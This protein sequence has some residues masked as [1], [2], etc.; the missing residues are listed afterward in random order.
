MHLCAA[1]FLP[2]FLVLFGTVDVLAQDRPHPARD[3]RIDQIDWIDDGAEFLD[4]KRFKTRLTSK[5][6]AVDRGAI[7]DGALERARG[8]GQPLLW[9][10]YKIS[11][12]TKRGRQLIRAPVL[13]VYMRQ[14]IWNDAAVER[15]VSASFVPLRMVCDE[16]LCQRLGLRPPECL[17]PAV[18]FF[19]PDGE[20]LHVL[21]T[22]R[23]FDASWFMGVLRDVLRKAHGPLQGGDVSGALDRG[24]FAAADALLAEREGAEPQ[25]LYTRA[26]MRRRLRDGAG[27][28]AALGKV[29]E[30]WKV[31][32]GSLG[33]RGQRGATGRSA[34]SNPQVRALAELYV[35]LQV[36][37]GAVLMALGRSEEA[38]GPLR[39]AADAVVGKRRAEARYRLALIRLLS[40]DEAGALR[41]FQAIVQEHPTDRWARRA[42]PNLLLGVDDHRP[43]GATFLGHERTRWLPK[44]AQV[45]LPEDSRWPA[46]PPAVDDMVARGVRLILA[47]QRADGGWNDARYAYCPDVRIT[48]NVWV[49]ISA[50]CCQALLRHRDRVPGLADRIDVAVQRG[51]RYLMDASRINRGHN[52]DVYADAYRLLHLARHHGL[53]PDGAERRRLKLWMRAI[54]GDVAARQH[55]Q[56]FWAHEY[57]NAFCTAA[58]V[59]GLV[60]ARE[61][62]VRI[63]KDVLEKANK[64]LLSARRKNGS[65]SYG[66]TAGRGRLSDLKNASTRMPMCEAALCALGASDGERVEAAFAAFWKHLPSIE[67]VRRTDFH[68]DGEIAGF[69]FF[70]SIYHTSEA[71][72]FLPEDRR[73]PMHRRLLERLRTYSEIDGTFMDSHEMGRSYATSMALLVIANALDGD[74]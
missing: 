1:R 11:E 44:D 17:E 62:G 28:L 25:G 63:P 27:A 47:Q 70:H 49:A 22:I 73:A 68:T 3:L 31:A 48:P 32:S 9:Y 69:M 45:T 13:D 30:A 10:V 56:G 50:L 34:S 66:G 20:V 72:A 29:D 2:C 61:A 38:V 6:S 65:F 5:E 59:E 7:L 18:V 26:V 14:L 16:S 46:S 4:Q 15:V 43:L 40:G 52:E 23:T 21:R 37:R 35:D 12:R 55:D 8:A 41:R 67:A 58:M 19:A 57:T 51:E 36:E 24:E 39:R 64:A 71:I 33:R 74:R 53:A 54:V 42:R 60:A